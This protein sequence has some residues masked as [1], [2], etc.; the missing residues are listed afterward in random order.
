M[1]KEDV[2]KYNKSNKLIESTMKLLIPFAVIIM[3][4]SFAGFA[5]DNLFT[6]SGMSTFAKLC[7]ATKVALPSIVWFI[8]ISVVFIKALF[9]KIRLENESKTITKDSELLK[10]I[11]RDGGNI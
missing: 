8:L 11:S 7:V 9:K 1:K 3:L 5:Y 4:M 6:S 10:H 2:D